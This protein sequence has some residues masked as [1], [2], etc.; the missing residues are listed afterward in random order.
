MVIE[1]GVESRSQ[2]NARP[3][4]HLPGEAGVWVFIIGDMVVFGA[5]FITFILYRASNLSLYAHSQRAMNQFF[6]VTNTMLLLASSWFVAIAVRQARRGGGRIVSL[7]INAAIACGL[8]FGVVKVF[9]YRE[10]LS[11][12][13]TLNSNEFYMFYYMFTGIHLMH[14]FVGVGVLT[15]LSIARRT[16]PT[17]E[18][19]LVA[20]ESG[21]SFWHLV[22]ILWI[23]LFALFYLLR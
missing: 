15:V 16:P 17:S 11:A 10:K 12:G 19:E 6:G 8:L 13:V 18:R 22:D 21:A 14:V 23:I 3:T 7:L 1:I 4:T 2:P 9:E 20:L 5:F